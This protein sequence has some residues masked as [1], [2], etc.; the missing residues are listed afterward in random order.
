MKGTLVSGYERQTAR[1]DSS[2]QP[3][4]QLL[5]RRDGRLIVSS[6]TPPFRLSRA[7]AASLM[8]VSQLAP[9]VAE[10]VDRVV[11]DTFVCAFDGAM[12]SCMA[13]SLGAFWRRS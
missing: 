7:C 6:Y 5:R 11:R 9:S 1:G 3:K 10:Q 8:S 2:F 13:V 4:L 12:A